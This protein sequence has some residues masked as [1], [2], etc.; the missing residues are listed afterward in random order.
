MRTL[1]VLSLAAILA[2][3]AAPADA[4]PSAAHSVSATGRS[5]QIHVPLGR[6]ASGTGVAPFHAV[7]LAP[8]KAGP[9]PA[10]TPEFN[11]LKRRRIAMPP[12]QAESQFAF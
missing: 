4:R 8:H 12:L 2:A 3:G 7:Q 10:P 1:V 6:Q 9:S 11:P 5:L